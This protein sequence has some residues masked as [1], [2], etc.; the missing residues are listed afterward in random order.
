MPVVF[1]LLPNN[2]ALLNYDEANNNV[3]VA[4]LSTSWTAVSGQNTVTSELISTDFVVSSRYVIAVY[5]ANINPVTIKLQNVDLFLSDNGRVLSFNSKIK[6]D[7]QI[8][9][10]CKLYIDNDSSVQPNEQFLSSGKY[11]AIQSNI[12]TVEDD[13]TNHT[14]TIELT[15]SGHSQRP[16]FFTCPHLIHDL[17]F[18]NNPIIG[19]IRRYLSDFYWEFDSQS[20]A[21]SFPFFKFIDALT[22]S[23]G[24]TRIEYGAMYGFEIEELKNPEWISDYWTESSLV[25]VSKVRDEYVPWISQFTGE[26]VIKNIQSDNGSYYFDNHFLSRDFIEW[27]LRTR[28]YGS[29]GGTREAMIDSARQVLI[30]TK[31]GEPSTRVVAL[32]PY[33]GGDPFSISIKT[34]TNETLDVANAGDSSSLVLRAIEKARPMGYKITHTTENIFLFT[35]DDISLGVIGSNF[36]LD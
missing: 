31:N 19:L 30:K 9:T 4:D 17:A 14:A 27:Q 7:S 16:I 6:C 1:N 3:L 2:D 18:N 28:R 21:P 24:D 35:L 26:N 10:S 22:H 12:A 36:P 33:F 34:L 15:I 20:S 11:N 13:D 8:S 23:I 25:D 5:P 32:T 29:N